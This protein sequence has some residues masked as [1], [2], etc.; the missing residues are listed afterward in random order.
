MYSLGISI[1]C[2]GLLAYNLVYRIYNLGFMIETLGLRIHDSVL[3]AQGFELK[4]HG[5][6]LGSTV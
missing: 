5:L 1:S 2:Q 3:N 4:V 6:G